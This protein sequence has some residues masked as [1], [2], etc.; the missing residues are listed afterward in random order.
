MTD[1]TIPAQKFLSCVIRTK[2]RFGAG[3]VTDVLLGSKA[4]RILDNAHN[5][6]STYGIGKGISRTSWLE[7]ANVLVDEGY[8]IKSG[9]YNVLLISK[10]A[11]DALVTKSKIELPLFL[12]EEKEAKML[13]TSLEISPLN[14]LKKRGEKA[15]KIVATTFD[16]NDERA[17]RIASDLK[18]WRKKVAEEENIPPYIIFNDKTIADI[19][20]K[21][22]RTHDALLDVF[23]LG[24]A[25]SERYGSAIIRIVVGD[26]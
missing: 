6:L 26:D 10:K 22:P 14:R 24:K 11:H 4:Q 1:V 21:K 15:K 18:E 3:Y 2:Q 16:Q 7:L 20:A 25:K 23:G 8:L 17:V 5:Q 9:E 12:E 13:D 19:A